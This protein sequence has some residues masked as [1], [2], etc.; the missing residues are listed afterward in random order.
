[1]KLDPKDATCLFAYS[2][3]RCDVKHCSISGRFSH[4]IC[5]G[6][7]TMMIGEADTSSC[8]SRQ[9]GGEMPRM[10]RAD[11]A[12]RLGKDVQRW[13]LPSLAAP[14]QQWAIHHCIIITAGFLGQGSSLRDF[15]F[16][17]TMRPLVLH[18]PP[19]TYL[20]MH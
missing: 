13:M 1:M 10:T 11:K 7:V 18:S 4:G 14:F 16:S 12:V 9:K 2:G 19:R 17:H 15:W 3:S 5:S 6:F 20:K 8:W